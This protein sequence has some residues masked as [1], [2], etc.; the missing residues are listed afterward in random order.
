MFATRAAA[1]RT[2]PS[3]GHEIPGTH[4]QGSSPLITIAEPPPASPAKGDRSWFGE[5]LCTFQSRDQGRHR[6][7]FQ[8]QGLS[9]YQVCRH[10]PPSHSDPATHSRPH[11]P[12][13]PHSRHKLPRLPRSPPR[14]LT[15]TFPCNTNHIP[16]NAIATSARVASGTEARRRRI[17]LRHPSR[18]CSD[19]HLPHPNKKRTV[20]G[21]WPSATWSRSGTLSLR[22]CELSTGLWVDSLMESGKRA[23]SRVP[24][25]AFARGAAE[26][27]CRSEPP[28]TGLRKARDGHSCTMAVDTAAVGDGRVI[29]GLAVV[30]A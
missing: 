26:S 3:R 8:S 23:R 14:H 18:E 24:A 27:P 19:L 1:S 20:P 7:P 12:S 11:R 15:T 6:K 16:I 2:S 22:G 5:G 21:W 28:V 29:E 30:P 13:R 10:T 25:Q 9:A 17:G 4:V